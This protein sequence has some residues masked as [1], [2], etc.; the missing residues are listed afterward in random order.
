MSEEGDKDLE[1][2]FQSAGEKL[3]AARKAKQ[4]SLADIS[5]KTRIT[6][7][8]LE[9]I[10]RGDYDELPG[11]TYAIG[12]SKSYAQVV[13][14]PESEI[15]EATRRQLDQLSGPM[16]RRN[17]VQFE[18]DE[19]SKV[20]PAALAWIAAAAALILLVAGF[21]V[22]RSYFFPG[23]SDAAV[24]NSA[25]YAEAPRVVPNTSQPADTVTD[26]AAGPVIFTATI[27]DVWVKFYDGA[28][29]QLFQ[30]R[31][32]KGES[33]TIPADAENPRIWTGRPDGFTITVGGKSVP[34][35]GTAE[36]AIKDV[37]VSAD[38]LL[39]RSEPAETSAV[40]SGTTAVRPMIDASADREDAAPLTNVSSRVSAARTSPPVDAPE[41]MRVRPTGTQPPSP[42]SSGTQLRSARPNS[43]A[44]VN[45][46]PTR[47]PL[48]PPPSGEA[49]A[50]P[51]N[52][53]DTAQPAD[54]PLEPGN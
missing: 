52:A 19:P 16:D 13:G 54:A 49:T 40:R 30:D 48:A 4:M 20:P 28:G 2:E 5:A 45:L 32:N 25:D 29:R 31:M 18:I 15:V 3:L 41:A 22:W 9:A 42:Q 27:D 51:D 44:G 33:F 11:R 43:A 50:S 39:A 10:E 1:F 34:P 53:A 12:F 6:Q 14:L 46:A 38:A 36:S 7:R 17:G 8:H 23:A 24:E 26:S 47:S 21:G 37:P 35:L